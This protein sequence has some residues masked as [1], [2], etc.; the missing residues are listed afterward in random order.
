M[1]HPAAQLEAFR[2]AAGDRGGEWAVHERVEIEG[3]VA[4]GRPVT[5]PASW[6]GPVRQLV[7][8]IGGWRGGN[9]GELVPICRLDQIRY[10]RDVH[11]HSDAGEPPREAPRS[12]GRLSLDSVTATL[13]H[14]DAFDIRAFGD[15]FIS[16]GF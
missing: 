9:R 6:A 4:P 11:P 8:A 14:D 13:N 10:E 16:I 12:V 5:D 7:D 3:P 1:T 2:L 15:G